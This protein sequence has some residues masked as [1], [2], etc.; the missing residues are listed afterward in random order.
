MLWRALERGSAAGSRGWARLSIRTSPSPSMSRSRS[1]AVA[2][3]LGVGSGV[4]VWGPGWGGSVVV[5][6]HGYGCGEMSD[7]ICN[8]LKYY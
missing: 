8:R 3:G 2:V 7:G 1:E 5:A 6:H 4:R